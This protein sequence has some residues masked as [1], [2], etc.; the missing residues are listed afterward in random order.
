LNVIVNGEPIDISDGSTVAKLLED[1]QIARDRV[2]V[3]VGLEIVPKAD[4]DTHTIRE[5]DRVEIV[6]FV[7]GG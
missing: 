7:G 1:L 6:R 2:A 3:E 4:Y 5:G